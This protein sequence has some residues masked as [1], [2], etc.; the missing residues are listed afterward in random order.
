MALT[1]LDGGRFSRQ[2]IQDMLFSDRSLMAEITVGDVV[3]MCSALPDVADACS[4]LGKWDKKFTSSSRGA[5]LF[6]RFWA[7]VPPGSWKVPFNAANPVGT[8]N[9]LNT[10]SPLVRKA[11]TDA[12]AELRAAAISFD[13]PLGDNQYVVRNGEKISVPGAPGQLGVLNVVTP[14]WNKGNVEVLHGSSYIQAVSFDGSPCPDA[15]TLVTY[16]QSSDPTSP[17][18]SDQTKLF[19]QGKWVSG[20]YCERDILSSPELK[21][22]YLHG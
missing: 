9:T 12:V 13:A 14:L 20:R 19:S 21:V 6:E 22:V 11:F 17:H 4:A 1:E 15:Q 16:S 3:K 5:L 8:P 2:S 7:K 10:D 18:F